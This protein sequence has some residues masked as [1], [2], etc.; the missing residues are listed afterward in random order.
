MLYSLHIIP[1]KA[2]LLN[3]LQS[4]YSKIIRNN[5]NENYDTKNPTKILKSNQEIRD[6]YKITTVESHL[7]YLRLKLYEKWKLNLSFAYLNNKTYINNILNKISNVKNQL[8]QDISNNDLSI[9]NNIFPNSIFYHSLNETK[10]LNLT[11]KIKKILHSTNIMEANDDLNQIIKMIPTTKLGNN[12]NTNND[13]QIL[14]K[15]EFCNR[16]FENKYK[17]YYHIKNT[18]I[19]QYIIQNQQTL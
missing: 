16:T 6:K 8:N 9:L 12:I 13:E 3:K 4:F 14:Y 7:E 2:N 10:K 1:L 19:L 18:P 17:L 5:L 11:N 15:C